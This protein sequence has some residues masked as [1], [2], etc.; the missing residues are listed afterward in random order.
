MS[1]IRPHEEKMQVVI[2]HFGDALDQI[3]TG[4][5]QTSLLDG[6]KV[7]YYGAV[8]PLNTVASV[9]SEGN[10]VIIQ[11]FDRNALDDIELAIRQSKLGINPVNDG[12]LIRIAFPALTQELREQFIK[13]AHE[14]AEEARIALRTIR[15]EVWDQVQDLE[16]Q[17]AI[18][19][20]DRYRR[21]EE[22][23]KLIDTFNQKIAQLA[24]QKETELKTP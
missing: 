19:K 20:D 10:Q 11:P 24:K 3:R 12:A 14:R 16:R 1:W 6:V 8:T 23:N 15:K 2:D 13:G 9:S 18:T 21:E 5:A 7:T 17:S 22:L 4:R